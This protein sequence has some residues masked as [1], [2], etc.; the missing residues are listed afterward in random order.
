[1]CANFVL[2][3]IPSANFF[4]NMIHLASE[5]ELL[6]Q[7]LVA[8][9][10]LF[11][12]RMFQAPNVKASHANTLMHAAGEAGMQDAWKRPLWHP[13][14]D[15]YR[16]ALVAKQRALRLLYKAIEDQDTPAD[17]LFK[18]TILF[19]NFELMHSGANESH[20]HLRGARK[21][22]EFCRVSAD[23]KTY[24]LKGFRNGVV[25]DYLM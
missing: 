3:N 13:F 23:A 7:L 18:C 5:S 12:Y 17:I 19:I 20:V 21:M 1:M 11:I 22:L 6:R 15:P 9:S 4:Q 8:S 25:F 16:D 14:G 10:A 24:A 2:Y